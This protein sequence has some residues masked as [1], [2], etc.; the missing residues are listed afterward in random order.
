[1]HHGY[2][3]HERRPDHRHTCRRCGQHKAIARFRRGWAARSDHDLCPRCWRDSMNRA[4]ARQVKRGLE[5]VRGG[6]T[7]GGVRQGQPGLVEIE[8]A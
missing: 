8:A 2:Q 1:M 3:R 6:R 5:L 7:S 4:R